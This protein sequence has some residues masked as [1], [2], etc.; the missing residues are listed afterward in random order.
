[1]RPHSKACVYDGVDDCGQTIEM[2]ALLCKKE[3]L[4]A[5]DPACRV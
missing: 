4:L 1:V 3:R 5:I 2:Q